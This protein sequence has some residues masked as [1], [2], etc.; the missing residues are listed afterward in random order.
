VP[1]APPLNISDAAVKLRVALDPK[2]ALPSRLRGTLDLPPSYD[3]LKPVDTIAPVMAH[4]TFNDA[5]YKPLRD[6]S[7]DLLVPNL[8]LIPN[9]TI[10]LME[11]NGRF[12]ESYMVGLNHEMARELLWRE[13]P[14]DQRGSYFRQFWDVG[15][16]LNRD[17]ASTP[18]QR[19][20]AL[21]DIK[22]LHE[23]DRTTA[24]GTHDN[25]SLPTGAEPGDAR[26]VV[27]IRGELLKKYPTTLVYAQR[28]RWTVD[29]E[30]GLQV[31]VLDESTPATNLLS[32]MFKAEVLPDIHFFGFNLT[33]SEARGSTDPTQDPGWFIVLQE[34]PGEPRFAMDVVDQAD[35]PPVTRWRELTW[36]HLG[37]PESIDAVDLAVAPATNIP[38]GSPDSAITW[39]SNAAEMAY[40]LFQNPVMVAFHAADMLE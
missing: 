3:P 37:D 2:I 31:R 20:E 15:D 30:S 33:Q 5:M 35:P 39:G 24:L 40:I 11:N 4:P 25:R 1:P 23:W 26:L 9:N 10:S 16:T 28:A 21:R 14:T 18:A 17:T 19:E 29:P 6:L 27:V 38:A 8:N 22:P 34:R 32:P 7:A 12:I 13:Y 36:N